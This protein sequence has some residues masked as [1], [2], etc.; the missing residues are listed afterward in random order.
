MSTVIEDPA[1]PLVGMNGK[2]GGKGAKMRNKL[3]TMRS[4]AQSFGAASGDSDKS[5]RFENV[6]IRL[7]LRKELYA[8]RKRIC[9]VSLAMAVLGIVLMILETELAAAHIFSRSDTA[10]ILLKMCMTASTVALLIFIFIYHKLGVQLFTVNNSMDDWRLAMTPMRVCS[11]L[12]ELLICLVHPIPGEFYIFWYTTESDG[13][14]SDTP[15]KVPLDVLLSLPMFLRLYLVCRFLMLHSRLYQDASSQSLGALNRIHFNFRFIFKSFMALYPDYFLCIF[16]VSLFIITSWTLRLCE[17]YNDAYHA[18]VHGNFLNSMWLIA[19]S[20]LTVGYG[21]I[22]PNSYCGRGIAV[23]TGIMGTGCTALIVAVLARKLELSQAE[24]Y[25]HNFVREIELGG[26]LK[27]EAANVV[28]CGWKL[29]KYQRK[30]NKTREEE[31]KVL[32]LQT[33][34]LHAIYN[35][36]ELKNRRRRLTDNAVTIVEVHKAQNEMS[37]AVTAVRAGQA[38]LEERLAGVEATLALVYQKLCALHGD[39][40]PYPQPAFPYRPLVHQTARD[41][42]I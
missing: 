10:S 17:M 22:V 23:L 38:H 11:A 7:A 19:V 18:R 6:G 40:A 26:R 13:N 25:V 1:I 30:T 28:K 32:Q 21:D 31:R 33:K 41:S 34:L 35:I 24:K 15:V 36:R 39:H 20:F 14:L 16:M 9:D 2:R 4:G 37:R 29:F 42:A 5:P 3:Y 8:K 27:T 12:A